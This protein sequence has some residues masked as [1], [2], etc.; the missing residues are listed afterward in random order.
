MI[1]KERE[2]RSAIIDDYFGPSETVSTGEEILA[3]AEARNANRDHTFKSPRHLPLN[4]SDLNLAAKSRVFFLLERRLR[5]KR[6]LDY[7]FLAP[8]RSFLS[9]VP[10]PSFVVVDMTASRVTG[11]NVPSPSHTLAAVLSSLDLSRFSL[12]MRANIP[13]INCIHNDCDVIEGRSED[14]SH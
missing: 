3:L 10:T 2:I 12:A 11:L 5:R 13:F 1:K 14:E 6:K 9:C 8:R 4:G 7:L